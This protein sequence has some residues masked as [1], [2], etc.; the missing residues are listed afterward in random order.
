[1]HYLR[2]VK[3][4]TLLL[5]R[6]PSWFERVKE[7]LH[8]DKFPLTRPLLSKVKLKTQRPARYDEQLLRSRNFERD[9]TTLLPMGK[10]DLQ[11]TRIAL[12]IDSTMKATSI[13]NNTLMDDRVMNLSCSLLKDIV[14]VTCKVFSPAANPTETIPFPPLLMYSKVIDHLSLRGFLK[15]LEGGNRQLTEEVMTSEVVSYIEAMRIVIRCVQRKKPTA[16][17]IFESH[18]GYVYLPKPLQQFLYLLSE[19]AS[20]QNLYFYVV[21]PYLRIC[22][23]TWRPCENSYPAFL[24]EVSKALQAYTG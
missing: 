12:F 1:M 10:E 11:K 9:L 21:A 17:K 16:R 2:P 15:D 22:A 20:A 14:E 5:D 13:M 24:P 4:P 3:K 18:P 23:M 7:D 6:I 19:G 8:R